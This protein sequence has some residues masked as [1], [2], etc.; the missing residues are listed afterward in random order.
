MM[1]HFPLAM[2]VTA[3]TLLWISRLLHQESRAATLAMVG[4]WNLCL[5]A[6]AALFAIFTGLFAT[7]D[8]HVGLAA[9]QA[10]AIHLKWAIF[11]TLALIFLAIW[12]GAGVPAESRPSWLFILMLAGATGALI[13]TGYRG[14][15]NVYQY[16]VGVQYL[17]SHQ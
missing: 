9:H 12:R 17:V 3:A 6:V 13:F 1:V 2:V 15:E 11:T 10:I 7:F 14:A 8:L 16:G 5:G 4:T